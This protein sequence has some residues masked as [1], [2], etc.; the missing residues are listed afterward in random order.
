MR[1][2][3]DIGR[4]RKAEPRLGVRES[5]CGRALTTTKTWRGRPVGG[6]GSDI[7]QSASPMPSAVLSWGPGAG[8]GHS[9][10][11]RKRLGHRKYG[12]FC[13]VLG[14]FL[15]IPQGSWRLRSLLQVCFKS[16][17]RTCC[18]QQSVFSDAFSRPPALSASSSPPLH[19][20]C[21]RGK[22]SLRGPAPCRPG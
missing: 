9:W 16:S 15:A 20:A 11:N 13:H 21:R 1:S 5:T 2:L 8:G 10:H 4:R 19:P 18:A 12:S 3:R 7:A 14:P 17:S 6:E 22:T